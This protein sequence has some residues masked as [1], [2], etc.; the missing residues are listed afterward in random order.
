MP[1]SCIQEKDKIIVKSRY[2]EMI[3]N[4]WCLGKGTMPKNMECADYD[5][6]YTV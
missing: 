5:T 1:L 6:C 4:S 3:F 2:V